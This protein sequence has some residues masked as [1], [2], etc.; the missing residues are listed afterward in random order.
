M[1]N[2][3]YVRDDP[4]YWFYDNIEDLNDRGYDQFA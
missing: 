3:T 1:L 4:H 2:G